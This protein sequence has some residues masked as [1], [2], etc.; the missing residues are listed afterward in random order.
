MSRRRGRQPAD[1][2]ARVPEK[3]LPEPASRLR[4][5]ASPPLLVALLAAAAA[6]WTLSPTGGG[7]GVTCDEWYDAYVG[8]GYVTA[9]RHEGLAFFRPANIEQHMGFALDGPPHHPPLGF[10]LIGWAH[11][12]IDPAPDDSGALYIP[13]ARFASVVEY[14]VLVWL[15][16]AWLARR[17]GAVAGAA[18]SAAVALVPRVFGHAHLAALDVLTALAIFGALLALIEATDRG[19]GWR[20]MALA[21]L[22]WGLALLVKLH[23][24]LVLAP[25]VAW[26]AWRYRWQAW[27]PLLAWLAAGSATFFIGWPWLWLNPVVHALHHFR[28]G[29][30]RTPLHCYYLGQVW[31]D[32]EVPWHYPWVIFLATVP[33]GFLLLGGLGL[34]TIRPRRSKAAASATTAAQGGSAGASPSRTSEFPGSA[35]A[36]ASYRLLAGTLTLL[37]L[38]FSLPG[39]PVYDGA[40]LFLAA[41]PLWAVLVGLGARWLWELPHWRG[42]PVALRGAVVGALLLA[43][44][45]GIAMYHPFY[46]SHYSLAVGGLDGAE[47]LGLETT[48]W[49]DTLD[50]PLLSAAAR[51]ARDAKL[52][53]APA[54]APFQTAGVQVST[55]DFAPNASNLTLVGWDPA[56]PQEA[57][58]CRLA[59]V[60]RRRADLAA[61]AFIVEDPRAEVLAER[62]RGGVWLARLYRLPEDADAMYR[63]WKEE[64]RADSTVEGGTP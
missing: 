36:V 8:K 61:A 20:R 58:G 13:A 47:Q 6:A 12:L 24:V 56:A 15:V 14:G 22:V 38:A 50:G 28:S 48:Y 39:V 53:L 32:V 11:W 3:Q 9:L 43:Q 41:Y 46:L 5:L 25:V 52:L 17:E 60:Y 44:A 2:S 34:W 26:L 33:L 62:S 21:G 35:T 31:K 40:R 16:G 42:V 55:P 59:L 1:R 7:P 29:A 4:R 63:R 37:L 54:L 51:E 30:M 23:G 27:K 45:T 19:G 18:A 10:W 57:T 49:G 64:T